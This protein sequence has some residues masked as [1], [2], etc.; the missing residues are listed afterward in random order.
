MAL[1]LRRHRQE[2][3]ELKVVAR[4]IVSLRTAWEIKVFL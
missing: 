3:W 1:A 4:Y 2:D